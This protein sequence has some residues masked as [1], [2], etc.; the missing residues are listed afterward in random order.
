MYQ[1][2]ADQRNL[3]FDQVIRPFSSEESLSSLS[4]ESLKTANYSYVMLTKWS[5]YDN[6]NI[7]QGT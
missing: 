5:A 1:R 3:S 4:S 6:V 2:S 7:S